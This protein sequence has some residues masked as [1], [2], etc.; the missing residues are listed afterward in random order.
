[1]GIEQ[2]TQYTCDW[3]GETG[4]LPWSDD[5]ELPLGWMTIYDSDG[6]ESRTD[7]DV[8]CRRCAVDVR[9]IKGIRQL[10]NQANR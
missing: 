3:C 2:I 7:Y 6:I 9:S 10:E 8:I 5:I 4:T 1:M